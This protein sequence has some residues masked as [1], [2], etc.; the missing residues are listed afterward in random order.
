[1]KKVIKRC[2]YRDGLCSRRN[3]FGR[4]WHHKVVVQNGIQAFAKFKNAVHCISE[5]FNLRNFPAERSMLP[6][7]A[8]KLRSPNG[9]YR[10][11]IATLY[12]ISRPLY[13]KILRPPEIQYQWTC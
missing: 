9:R 3:G 13:H 7:L 2:L 5:N 6:K 4:W 1:M 8:R 12:H 10:A 11:N